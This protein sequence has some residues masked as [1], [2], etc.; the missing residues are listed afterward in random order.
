MISNPFQLDDSSLNERKIINH[1]GLS[2]ALG[3]ATVPI[4]LSMCMEV[5][6]LEDKHSPYD[7]ALRKAIKHLK[8]GKYRGNEEY[9][10]LINVCG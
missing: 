4:I 10:E 5:A 8:S 1:F 7:E 6:F 2:D 3:H 9:E